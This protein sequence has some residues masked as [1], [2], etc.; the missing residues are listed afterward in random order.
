[1]VRNCAAHLPPCF[2][3]F[4]VSPILNTFYFIDP[5]GK[6]MPNLWGFLCFLGEFCVISRVIPAVLCSNVLMDYM[7]G[8]G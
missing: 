7:V 5:K 2:Q 8:L 4:A 6:A 3:I 1:M